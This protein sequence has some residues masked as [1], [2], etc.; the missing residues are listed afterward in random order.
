MEAYGDALILGKTVPSYRIA[1]E[2]EIDSWKAFRKALSSD[3]ERAAFDEL[4][5]VC[6]NNSM[7]SGSAC[8]PIIFEH[9]VMSI[10]L[11]RQKKIKALEERLNSLIY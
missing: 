10:L 8:K 4:M 9:M 7:A 5:D 6:R 3:A 1:L 2:F 11:F